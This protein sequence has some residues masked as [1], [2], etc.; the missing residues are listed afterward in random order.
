MALVDPQTVTINAVAEVMARTGMTDTQGT[1]DE[2][3]AGHQLVVLQRKTPKRFRHTI[4]LN[5]RKVAADPFTSGVNQEYSMSTYLVIDT[6]RVGY[7]AAEAKLDVMGFLAY[8]SA[9]SGAIV[10]QIIGGEL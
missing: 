8:L 6:P 5:S 2:S 7:T 10:A 1:F 4:R 9:S 3:D